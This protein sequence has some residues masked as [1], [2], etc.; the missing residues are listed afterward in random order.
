MTIAALGAGV[1]SGADEPT[2]LL[3]GTITDIRGVPLADM[4]VDVLKPI[5]E[6]SAT[7]AASVRTGVDGRYAVDLPVG[8]YWMR[9]ADCDEAPPR[10][11]EHWY[12]E[13]YAPFGDRV[14]VYEG[15]TTTVDTEMQ[16]PPT[17]SGRVTDGFGDPVAG[18][19]VTAIPSD[20]SS[21]ASSA[22]ATTGA[23]GSYKIADGLGRLL[24][25]APYKINAND[26]GPGPDRPDFPTVWWRGVDP[27]T[28][29]TV[30]LGREEDR[31]GIDFQVQ[32]SSHI[33]GKVTDADGR[34]LSGVCV[35]TIAAGAEALAGITGENGAFAGRSP[36][37]PGSYLLRIRPCGP[38]LPWGNANGMAPEYW[39]NRPTAE[40]AD[41]VIVEPGRDLTGIDVV[42]TPAGPDPCVVPP[43][44]GKRLP[45]AQRR[46]DAANC[47]L[48]KVTEET[49]EARAGRILASQPPKGA[50]R[51]HDKKVKLKVSEGR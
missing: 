37:R 30:V 49:G 35:F 50:K 51:R 7:G 18:A 19:C 10:L 4:C 38:E 39:D 3:K 5:S 29:E 43:L 9:F 8:E 20:T 41:P 31:A 21:G 26:C 46:L 2:G 47:S 40:T 12:P 17:V 1:A 44:E 14:A 15:A 16:R 34:P 48:G 32:L 6:T 13:S 25:E 24:A 22:S 36:V 33:L 28:A 45:R 27:A 23:D 42:L 11:I